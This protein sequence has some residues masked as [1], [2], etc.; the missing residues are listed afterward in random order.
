MKI[1]RNLV[2]YLCFRRI[3]KSNIRIQ[4]RHFEKI[5]SSNN[6]DER[7]LDIAVFKQWKRNWSR[8]GMRPSPLAYKIFSRYIGEDENIVPADISRNFIEPILTPTDYQPFYNDKNSFN[9]FIDNEDMPRVIVRSIK[10]HMMDEDY[11]IIDEK[12]F[13]DILHDLDVDQ[14][15]VKPSKDQGGHGVKMFNA[16]GNGVFKDNDGNSLSASFLKKHYNTDF[17]VQKCIKQCKYLSQFNPSSVNTI[18]LAIYRDVNTGELHFLGAVLRIGAKDACVDNAC[19]GGVFI[20]IDKNGKLGSYVCNVNG[21]KSSV[22]NGIDFS[23]NDY[24]IPNFESIIAFAKK[25]DKRLPH[26][27]L[28]ANDITVDE[29]DEPKLIE[30]NT[31]SF[32][33]WLY[34]FTTKP[35]F[36]DYTEELIDFCVNEYKSVK[37]KQVIS[38]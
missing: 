35:V 32:S 6:I 18:R 2:K 12:K 14:L 19:S 29:N 36:G 30:V 24:V 25:I 10:H 33:Y 28:Y 23:K 5:I 1:I 8:F 7:P 17:V 27:C 38:Y 3:W 21:V 13:D 34:Q 4:F 22:H 20:G 31:H 37:L 11:N 9:L 16:D 15:I 26:M